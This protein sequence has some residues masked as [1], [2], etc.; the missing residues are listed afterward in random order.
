MAVKLV[1]LYTHPEDP[2]AFDDHYTGTHMPLVAKVPGIVRAET[3]K[4]AAAAD[5]R[6]QTYYRMAE[7]WFDSLDDLQSGLATEAGAAT[8]KDYRSIAPEGSRMFIAQ[9]D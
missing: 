2:Q 7:L 9:V 8:A 5:G 1:V 3:A 4:F 6:E